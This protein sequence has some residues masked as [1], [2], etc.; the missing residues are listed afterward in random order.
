MADCTTKELA[1]TY[2][3]PEDTPH[4]VAGSVVRLTLVHNSGA[5]M[6][7]SF[8]RFSRAGFSIAALLALLALTR[9]Y[10]ATPLTDRR[11]AAALALIVGGAVGN[12]AN[13]LLLP[14]GVTDFID[15]GLGSW[16]F[17]TFNVADAGITIG[18]VLLAVVLW[19]DGQR[20]ERGAR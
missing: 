1:E 10:N 15:V 14:Q 16:R 2:L 20:R 5:A 9:L 7:L 12:L 13:R 6:S 4:Q 3:V 8:G 11:R 19:R 17:W 18:A